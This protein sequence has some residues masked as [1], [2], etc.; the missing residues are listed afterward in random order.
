M[1]T[2][3]SLLDDPHLAAAGFFETTEHPTEG[4]IRTIRLPMTWSKSAARP[5]RPAPNLGEH[6]AEVLR[7][8]GFG[9]DEIE[10]LVAAGVLGAGAPPQAGAIT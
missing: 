4:S 7:E 2:L 6:G 8:S 3:D 1:N 9:A 5:R 10:T